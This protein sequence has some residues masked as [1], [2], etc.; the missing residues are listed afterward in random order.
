[1]IILRNISKTYKSNGGKKP[2]Q[3]LKNL[4]L[5]I[6]SDE[7]IAIE[8]RS[9]TGKTTLLRIITGMDVNFSGN[10]NFEDM[11]IGKASSSARAR[12]REK[13]LGII[14]QEFDLLDDRNVYEN[15]VLAVSNRKIEAKEKKK[16]VADVLDYVGLLGFEKKK[17]SQ[18]SGGEMQ[19]VGIA[20]ALIK[21]PRIIVADEPTG[22][23]DD[24]TREEILT[25]FKKIIEDGGKFIIVTHDKDVS[26]ICD[27]VYSLKNGALELLE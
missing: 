3:V 17:I 22:S 4:Y 15:I 6:G 25:V 27:K 20:R 14:T 24:Q 18:L 11:D 2:Q 5:T 26:S 16:Q 1:M 8:G 13:E 9:G 23:L 10:Y 7:S 19:R 21:K 12:L